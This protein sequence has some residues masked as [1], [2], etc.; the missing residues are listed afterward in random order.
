MTKIT[1]KITA[2]K[3]KL[4]A[5]E[6]EQKAREP[7]RSPGGKTRSRKEENRR[8]YELGGLLKIANLF[9]KIKGHC[10]ERF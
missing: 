6:A 3:V 1:E 2:L 9:D 8:K 4:Q 10:S 5:L 7:R